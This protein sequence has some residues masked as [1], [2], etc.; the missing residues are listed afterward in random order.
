MPT[1]PGGVMGKLIAEPGLTIPLEELPKEGVHLQRR[2][3]Y[4]RGADGSTYVWIGR[5]RSIGT[6]EG[7]SG[8]RFDYLDFSS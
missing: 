2:Y 8:L 3:R 7:R 5:L 4:A 6:G 1:A